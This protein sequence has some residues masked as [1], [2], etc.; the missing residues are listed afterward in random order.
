MIRNKFLFYF[1][2]ITWGCI[3]TLIGAIVALA[4]I[5]TGHKPKKWGYCWYFEV[6]KS[7]WG[8]M[9]LGPFF[10]CNKNPSERIKNHEHGHGHQNCILG[11]LM[12][13]IVCIPSAV[14]YWL[15]EFKDKN[16]KM[17]FASLIYGAFILVG[18]ILMALAIL[19]GLWMFI[20]GIALVVYGIIIQTWLLYKE[21]PQ[22][23]IGYVEYD[24][25]WFEKNATN[26]GFKFIEWYNTK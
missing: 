15:R 3:M 17:F 13:F 21:I 19:V 22:Y 2:S 6:G 5:I 4:L 10:L 26:T 7:N 16:S 12:P 25:I 20:L 24:A 18:A 8:G 9:E 1:L 23:D 14:R 11:P